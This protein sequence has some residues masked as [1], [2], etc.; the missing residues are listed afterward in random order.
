MFIALP[1]LDKTFTCTL[2]A[3]SELF[4]KVEEDPDREILPLFENHFPGVFPDLISPEDLKEQFKRNPHLPLINIKCT[5][6]HFGSSVVIVGDAANAVVPFYGQGMNAGLESVHILFQYLD[7]FGVYSSHSDGKEVEKKRALALGAYT[8]FRTPD[9]HA[10]ADLALRNYDEMK[11]HVV[12]P[13]YKLRKAVEET[14]DKY[15]PQLGW[16]T[17]YSRVSFS[18]LRY[19]EVEA[20]AAK[21]SRVF[22][23]IFF[24][25][26]SLGLG[27]SGLWLSRLLVKKYGD[28][29]V[30]LIRRGVQS[31]R[32]P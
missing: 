4:A 15:F 31:S 18:N 7:R 16:A 20:L 27:G 28:A 8:K 32:F 21:Q 24:L 10:I 22:K 2:F 14:L 3:P 5:P 29:S 11:S 12:S 25:L 19:S 17:Q 13:L 23:A 1:S 6:H 9:A 30:A 26:L